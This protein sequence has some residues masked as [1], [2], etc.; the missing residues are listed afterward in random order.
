MNKSA[1][2]RIHVQGEANGSTVKV[3]T[4]EGGTDTSETPRK[5]LGL[6]LEQL[7]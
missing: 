3:L 2:Y 5:I 4:R 6:L 1:Q 7:K